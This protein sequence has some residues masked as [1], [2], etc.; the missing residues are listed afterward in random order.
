MNKLQKINGFEVFAAAFTSAAQTV[1]HVHGRGK[2]FARTRRVLSVLYVIALTLISFVHPAYA[3]NKPDGQVIRLAP[4][5]ALTRL[6]SSAK[7]AWYALDIGPVGV[8][9]CGYVTCSFYFKRS[10]TQLIAQYGGI[11]LGTITRFVP[12]PVARIVMKPAKEF[13]I[14]KAKEA[15]GKNECLRFRYLLNGQLIGVYSDGSGF[16]RD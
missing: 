13:I 5:V 1:R 12:N 6:D 2:R 9:D 7:A 3:A 14:S 4:S 11:Y 15:A 16:C 10:V 8:A